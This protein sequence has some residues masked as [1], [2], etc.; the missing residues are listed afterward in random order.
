MENTFYR[1]IF[2]IQIPSE[3]A[4]ISVLIFSL[5]FYLPKSHSQTD[6]T[7]FVFQDAIENVI[8]NGET[9]EFDYDTE[10][11]H[12]KDFIRHPLN[13][14]RATAQDFES[15][16]LLT[17][18][19]IR[20]IIQHREKQGLYI[21]LYELQAVLPLETILRIL[22]FITIDGNF[23]D[24]Q[25]PLKEWFKRGK[26]EA[27]GRVE[28]RLQEAEG[29]HK[30][31]SQGGF[32][33]DRFKIYMRYRYS[34]S[35]KLSYGITLEKDA[36]EKLRLNWDFKSV[37]FKIQNPTKHIKNLC[38]GDY[39]LSIGQGLIHDNGFN[40]GK[41]SMVL[42]IEKSQPVLKPYTA[43]NEFN[44]LRGV[45]FESQL[46][47][48]TEG[49]GWVSYRSRD[50]NLQPAN[51]AFDNRPFI[52]SLQT[53]GLH[54]TNRDLED[55]NALKILT[56]GV[57][58][59]H[60]LKKGQMG[61]NTILNQLDKRLDPRP[62][63]YNTYAFRGQTLINASIDYKYNIQNIHI[64]G[65]W[66]TSHKGGG[67]TVNGLLVG[68]DKKLSMALL[69]RYF[70][71]TYQALN[72]QPFAESYRANDEQ[73]LY[74]GLQYNFS[75]KYAIS[76]YSDFWRHQWW[77][78]RVDA[79]SQGYEFLIK[80]AFKL[81]NTEGYLQ[82]RTKMKQENTSRPDTLKT[83]ILIDKTRTQWRFQ[84]QHRL[85]KNLMLR[86]R[87]EMSRYDAET[88][89]KGFMAYQDIIYSTH[90]KQ[91]YPLS[92]TSRWAF[93]DTDNFDTAIYAYE[94]DVLNS[95]TVTPYYYRGVRFYF[96]IS[97]SPLPH[98]TAEWRLAH[99]YL[100]NKST[101]GSGLDEINGNQRTDMKMQVF[102]RF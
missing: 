40:M 65:E 73:G 101:I 17:T 85:S 96:N 95:F 63:P 93:F 54:R 35:N 3:Y 13:I 83:N 19:Q 44:F 69:H 79:P 75:K 92:I 81:K 12:L 43:S 32:V 56:A 25:L 11:E 10:L 98:F 58:I 52:S 72:A 66:A 48:H 24:F 102:Y 90:V 14:N 50:G 20:L 84:L 86:N 47:S 71:K 28:R 16:R 30:D 15:L 18:E 87:I 42:N 6:S 33:G 2:Y 61:L 31:T 60:K 26:R 67:A 77:R 1:L 4:R 78:F 27:F 53:S 9:S 99:T 36:G 62:E 51:D 7:Y 38:V 23:D 94:N 89:Y 41:S 74:A 57:R 22:P 80:G 68:L 39:A 34:F 97:Y 55:K 45:A 76:A 8:A 49:V 37:H 59:V 82:F 5:L 70:S 88:V 91:K 64:F 46:L 100:S 21:A 29:F